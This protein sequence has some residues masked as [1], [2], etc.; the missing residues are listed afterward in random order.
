M[1]SEGCEQGPIG[2][3]DSRNYRTGNLYLNIFLCFRI[4]V[5]GTLFR[6]NEGEQNCVGLLT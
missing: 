5:V 6:G 3:I 4:V 2:L 1:L